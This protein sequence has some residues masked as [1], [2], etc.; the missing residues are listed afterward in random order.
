MNGYGCS[1]GREP[2]A[3]IELPESR[4]AGAP[5]CER[6]Q[7]RAGTCSTLTTQRPSPR[8]AV[9]LFLCVPVDFRLVGV[10]A[11]LGLVCAENARTFSGNQRLRRPQRQ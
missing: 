5:S 10:A 1:L 6:D 3:A 2:K 4:N 11:I 7:H 8:V 9:S